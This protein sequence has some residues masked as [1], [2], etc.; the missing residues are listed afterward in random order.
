MPHIEVG[1]STVKI[2][3]KSIKKTPPDY[4]RRKPE[5]LVLRLSIEWLQV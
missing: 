1:G 3:M 4:P 5:A 2:W